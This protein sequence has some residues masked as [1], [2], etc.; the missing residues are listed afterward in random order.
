MLHFFIW[1]IHSVDQLIRGGHF[2]TVLIIEQKHGTYVRTN[3]LRANS[4]GQI[5]PGEGKVTPG[6]AKD[7]S[8]LQ[9]VYILILH[10]LVSTL[11]EN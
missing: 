7:M 4:K 3:D 11:S 6:K 8:L 9:K 2:N 1:Y 10:F 5:K